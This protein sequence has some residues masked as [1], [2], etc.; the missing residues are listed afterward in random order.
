MLLNKQRCAYWGVVS[1][2]QDA[3]LEWVQPRTDNYYEDEDGCGAQNFT[4]RP[5]FCHAIPPPRLLCPYSII[6]LL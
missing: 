2:A 6:D 4:T 3:L 1:G 5:P